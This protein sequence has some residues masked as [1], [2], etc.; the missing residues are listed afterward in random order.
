LIWKE[1]KDI[2]VEAEAN[3]LQ[4]AAYCIE[5]QVDLFEFQVIHSKPQMNWFKVEIVLF[6]LQPCRLNFNCISS[7]FN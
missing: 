4:K 3:G 1:R 6:E 7:R 5:E 2:L